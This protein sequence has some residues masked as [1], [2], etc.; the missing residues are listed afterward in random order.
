M[1]TETILALLGNPY[2]LMKQPEK[3]INRTILECRP[4]ALTRAWPVIGINHDEA[5]G[6]IGISRRT[7]DRRVA[8]NRF[9]LREADRAFRIVYTFA[10]AKDV[11]GSD[12]KARGWFRQKLPAL[13]NRTPVECLTTE[14]GTALVR[15]LL[16]QIEHGIYH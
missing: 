2:P 15:E 5:A 13:D 3:R 16:E 6:V 4:E 12:E 14:V 10:L 7:L 9:Q 8:D 1:P 11:L